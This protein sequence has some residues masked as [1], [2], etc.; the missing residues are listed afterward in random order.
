MTMKY[1][2]KKYK[3]IHYSEEPLTNLTNPPKNCEGGTCIK[4]HGLWVS[5]NDAWENWCRE[6]DFYVE[7]LAYKSQIKLDK[8]SDI[9]YLV[10]EDSFDAFT[11]EYCPSTWKQGKIK[12]D[13]R[14][15]N[16]L[17]V[18]WE[19]VKDKYK[20]LIIPIYLW[21]RRDVMWYYGW[22]CASGVIWD[23]SAIKS[24]KAL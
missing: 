2:T 12:I 10:N 11:L 23:I 1:M 9:L 19:K 20:G 14:S 15:I 18:D 17:F 22:D 21:K 3:F 13:N 4:P 24:I 6:E 7:H 16:Y 5:V 8:S